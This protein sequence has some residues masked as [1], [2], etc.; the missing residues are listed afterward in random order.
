MDTS[1]LAKVLTLHPKYFPE[2][3]YSSKERRTS[4]L[5]AGAAAQKAYWSAAGAQA[6]DTTGRL[7]IIQYSAMPIYPH[8]H[9]VLLR[10]TD[11]SHKHLQAL[12]EGPLSC[13]AI[14]GVASKCWWPLP[15][16]SPFVLGMRQNIGSHDCGQQPVVR[17][18]LSSFKAWSQQL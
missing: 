5:A 18:D 15:L 3:L 6:R 10:C 17:K 16:Q 1:G 7:A 9:A 13:S 4:T 11:S 14:V 8:G 12:R 2:E